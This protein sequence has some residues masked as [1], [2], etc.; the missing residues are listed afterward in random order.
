MSEDIPAAC[1]IGWPVAHSKSPLIHEYWLER[2][3]IAGAYRREEVRPEDF[4]DF[5]ASLA[6]HGYVGANV[7]LPHKQAALACSEPDKRARAVGAANTLWLD[8][9]RLHSTN[10]DV[11]GFLGA[12]DADAPGWDENPGIAVV[13]G[14]GGAARAVVYGLIERGFARIDVVNRTLSRAEALRG[15]FGPA[16]HPAD[17]HDAP[18]VLGGAG[19]L[20]NATS[21]GMAGKPA[22][23]IDIDALGDDAV[24]ADIVYTPLR[25][26]LLS[27]AQ[28]RGLRT[29]GGLGMLL[30]QA[31]GGFE[32]W[33]GVRP[34]VT[35]ALRAMVEGEL[36]K[37]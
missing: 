8:E 14:A 28:R 16:I 23:E 3:G 20:V 11:E 34:E 30:H 33:F 26:P 1:I 17:W 37:G 15:L 27:A 36:V 2:Y 31:V 22:L 9:G 13:L 21:L 25:T 29:S 6:A 32:L 5:V 10:T 19:L 18:N 4:A 7:T 24:V 35:G 12:L